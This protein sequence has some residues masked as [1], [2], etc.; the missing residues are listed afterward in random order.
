MYVHAFQVRKDGRIISHSRLIGKSQTQWNKCNQCRLCCVIHRENVPESCFIKSSIKCRRFYRLR[1]TLHVQHKQSREKA[2]DF[3][4]CY[5]GDIHTCNLFTFCFWECVHGN[6]FFSNWMY[7]KSGKMAQK[8]F[9][10]RV[11][12]QTKC[13]SVDAKKKC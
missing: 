5:V 11:V 9:L 13:N 3:I 2:G 4:G 7:C 1:Y 10:T 8:P 12:Q 6:A